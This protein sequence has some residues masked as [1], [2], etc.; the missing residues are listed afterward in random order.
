MAVR[1]RVNANLDFYLIHYSN[2]QPIVFN[3]YVEIVITKTGYGYLISIV[4]DSL[5]TTFIY[6]PYY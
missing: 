2:K 1:L 6:K 3:H 4:Y 5:F